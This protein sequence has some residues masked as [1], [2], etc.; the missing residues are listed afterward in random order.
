MQALQCVV[1][2]AT[3]TNMQLKERQESEIG[4]KNIL[5]IGRSGNSSCVSK[6]RLPT[7]R[8]SRVLKDGLINLKY[9]PQ[10]ASSDDP[11]A[12]F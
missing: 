9:Q 10:Y 11:F 6:S 3:A 5:T 12:Q 7:T 8:S 1:G 4:I 2:L